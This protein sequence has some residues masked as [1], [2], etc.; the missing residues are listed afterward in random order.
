VSTAGDIRHE[1]ALLGKRL[2]QYEKAKY[3]KYNQCSAELFFKRLSE[4]K[5]SSTGKS[6]RQGSI[7]SRDH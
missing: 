6:A 7:K 1:D 3:C 5:G 2:N 4:T